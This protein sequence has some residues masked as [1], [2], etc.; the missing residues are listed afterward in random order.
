[1][2]DGDG[3]GGGSDGRYRSWQWGWNSLEKGK[4]VQQVYALFLLASLRITRATPGTTASLY[5]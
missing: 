3:Y 2:Q 4:G 1:M 5:I